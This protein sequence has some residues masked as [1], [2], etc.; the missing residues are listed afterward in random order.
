MLRD[1]KTTSIAGR[2]RC[3]PLGGGN[4]LRRQPQ[5]S[6]KQWGV[7]ERQLPRERKRERQH[8]RRERLTVEEVRAV[9]ARNTAFFLLLA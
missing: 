3:P 7:N 6:D 2:M 8:R 4:V 1:A 9:Q 5:S